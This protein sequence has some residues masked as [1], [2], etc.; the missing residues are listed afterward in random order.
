MH[1]VGAAVSALLEASGACAV[2]RHAAARTHGLHVACCLIPAA[3][4][5]CFGTP[6]VSVRAILQAFATLSGLPL[7]HDAWHYVQVMYVSTQHDHTRIQET[8]V[9]A[10]GGGECDLWVLGW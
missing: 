8:R 10:R 9:S 2:P 5:P 6:A 7:T 3:L 4:A 1:A